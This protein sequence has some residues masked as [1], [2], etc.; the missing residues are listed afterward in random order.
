MR[1]SFRSTP[2]LLLPGALL[3]A[4]PLLDSA[5]GRPAASALPEP[6]AAAEWARLEHTREALTSRRRELAKLR[7][8]G[9]TTRQAAAADRLGREIGVQAAE[10]DR[11]LVSFINSDPPVAGG[12]LSGRQRAA[13][14]M[15]SDE[16]I[17]LAHDSIERGG[18][19]RR[20][21]E[22]YAA[23]LAVDPDNPRL[24]EELAAAERRRYLT[25][26]SFTRLRKGMLAGEVRELLGRPNPHDVREYQDRGIVAWFYSKDAAGA[27][28]AVWFI[29]TPG[30]LT[31]YG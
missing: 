16:D 5:C 22:I 11:R 28:A 4:L 9:I 29:R 25:A 14:R 31:V 2:R 19:Y 30:A 6:A 18:D 24:Q 12:P 7:A 13:L 26:G 8:S 3:L 17:E 23:A 10:L 21:I 1:E 20:A 15:K 27:A